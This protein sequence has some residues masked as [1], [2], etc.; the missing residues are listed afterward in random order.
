LSTDSD[1]DEGGDKQSSDMEDRHITEFVQ[2]LE[3]E[4][5]ASPHTVANY[6]MDVRQ[7]AGFTWGTES[8]PPFAW[9][10]TDRFAA[11]RF[12]VELQK[13][14]C[15]PSTTG[16]KLSSLKSFYRFL[17]REDVVK[18]SPFA[19]IAA[20]RRPR[21][22]PEILSV[23]E[24]EK[25]LAAPSRVSARLK[26]EAGKL[27]PLRGYAALRDT[28]LLEVLYSTGGR[29]SEIVGLEEGQ[30]DLLSGI[31]RVRGKG[32]KE[33]LCPLGR[34]ACTAIRA[35]QAAEQVLRAERRSRMESRPVF[36]NLK[37]GRLTS[38]SVERMMKKY[39]PEAGLNPELTPHTLR[40]SFA[41]H[42]LDAG[43]DLRSVQELL[44]HASLSTTQIYTHISVERLKKVYQDAHP[45]A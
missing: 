9:A 23:S 19:G 1:R 12:L 28:A 7:F 37:G 5:D 8:K 41:T 34:P 3:N 39:L 36:L 11:R 40:H 35:M 13:S 17:E 31:V 30:V 20:P 38:R 24:V 44:G 25:L 10:G 21:K 6:R 26:R 18:Q 43:A 27:D 14:G 45:R 15:E 33:R 42:M 4:R 29:V 16:R 32:K 22:L 2:Y